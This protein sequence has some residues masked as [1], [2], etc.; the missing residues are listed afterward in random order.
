MLAHFGEGLR[1]GDGARVRGARV[2]AAAG[3]RLRYVPDIVRT[4]CF[5]GIFEGFGYGNIFGRLTS[6]GK[7]ALR[8]GL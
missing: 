4:W 1:D 3:L 5:G 8:R 6:V 7:A 2:A